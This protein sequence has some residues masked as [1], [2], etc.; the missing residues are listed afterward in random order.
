MITRYEQAM[1]NPEFAK[2][3]EAEALALH[4][5]ELLTNAM[6]RNN[7]DKFFLV[8]PSGVELST[9]EAI[10]SGHKVDIKDLAQIFFAMGLKLE[11]S[12]VPLER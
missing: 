10:L 1:K 8:Q 5:G 11:I 2:L 12:V 6:H 4:V 3:L 9:I 7:M